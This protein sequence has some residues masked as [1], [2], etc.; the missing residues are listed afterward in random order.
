MGWATEYIRRLQEGET[1]QF[2]PRGN[3]MSGKIESGQLCTVEPVVDVIAVGDIVLCKVNGRQ[4]LHLVKAV[5]GE[6]YQIGNN[7]GRVNGW[8][9]R[10]SVYGKCVR[11]EP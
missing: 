11:V 5:R 8:V 7:R 10:N 9:S 6:R 3:S 1:V 2:R 4:Y